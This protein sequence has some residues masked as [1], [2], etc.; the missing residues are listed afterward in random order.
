MKY[1]F[2]G[3][4]GLRVSEVCLGTMTFGVS[5]DEA[6]AK[7]VVDTAIDC[8]V[9][10]MDTANSYSAGE[11]ENM[12]GKALVGHRRRSKCGP[13]SRQLRRQRLASQRT[14]HG[15]AQHRI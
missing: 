4:S 15:P 8:G 6:A 7:T 13:V 10:F 11:S 12:L 9:N 5:V 3:R 14:P 2:L 1:R